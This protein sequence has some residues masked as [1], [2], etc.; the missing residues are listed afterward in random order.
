MCGIAG[1]VDFENRGSTETRETIARAMSDAIRHRGP[2]ADGVWTESNG[3]AAVAF[4][5]RRLSIIDLTDAGRQPMLSRCGRWVISY[6]GEVYNFREIRDDL[7]LAGVGFRGQSDTEVI[8]EAI[9]RWGVERTIDRL[10][11]MF[12][13]ALWDRESQEL[14]LIRDRLGIK[15][16]YWAQRGQ[17]LFFGSELKSLRCFPDWHPHIDRNAVASFLRHCYIPAPH[18]IYEGVQKLEPGTIL[19]FGPDLVVRQSNYWSALECATRGADH[20]IEA[21]DGDAIQMLDSLLLDAVGRRMVA[22]V[23]LGAFLSGGVDSSCVAALMQ[24]QSD[25]PIRTFSIGFNVPEYNEAAHAKKIS[26]HLGTDHTELYVDERQALDLVPKLPSYYDEPF[27]DSS[28]LPTFLVSQMT[29][30]HVTVALSGDGGDELFGGYRRYAIAQQMNRLVG[31]AP[32]KAR[33]LIATLLKSTPHG[34]INK[35]GERLPGRLKGRNYG[36]RLA[37]LGRSNPD[38]DLDV[39]Y[40]QMMS[41]WRHPDELVRGAAEPKN[42]MFDKTLSERIPNLLSRMQAKDCVTYL[43]DDILTK[44][45]RASMAVSLEARVPLLDHRVVEFAWSL[46]EHMKVRNGK[47]KWL[48]RQV[49]QRYVPDEL[50]ERPKMGFGVPMDVWLRGP[51]KDW[52]WQ[53]LSS[54]RLREL[55]LLDMNLVMQKWDAHQRGDAAWHYQLWDVLMLSAWLEANADVC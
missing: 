12:A 36:D 39:L 49:L 50:I 51:L 2:D 28:Q 6:N 31:W 11:G 10:I 24:T 23:P 48:L 18:T 25:R 1:F 37:E 22:D 40:L 9:S 33:R 55:D 54:D 20:L 34:P 47:S 26:N 14:L 53:M 7:K 41:H 44:V 17:S 29:R 42:I 43:P 27:A 38:I 16:V 46:P 19:R 30:Q 35:L 5:H 3:G 15:P 13:L 32:I 21:N 8:L 45:D 4:G 52:A